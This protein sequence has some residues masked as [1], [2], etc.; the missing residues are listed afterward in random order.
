MFEEWGG[1]WAHISRA[2]VNRCEN[3]VQLRYKVLKK[4]ADTAGESLVTTVMAQA[5]AET[6]TA[7]AT[8]AA[9]TAIEKFKQ[10]EANKEKKSAVPIGE[11]DS[12]DIADVAAANAVTVALDLATNA[13]NVAVV[14]DRCNVDDKADL[15]SDNRVVS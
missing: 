1:K 5:A 7:T 12:D 4:R 15:G 8:N 13:A 11:A 6:E 14:G 9:L 2:L 10:I 3:S